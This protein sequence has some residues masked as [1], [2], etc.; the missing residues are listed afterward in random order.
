MQGEC[1]AAN[2]SL[3]LIGEEVGLHPLQ[4]WVDHRLCQQG[5]ARVGVGERILERI[6]AGAIGGDYGGRLRGGRPRAGRRRV[7]GV[8]GATTASRKKKGDGGKPRDDDR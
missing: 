5:V 6:P 3:T 4:L 7:G 2:D 1:P 8:G